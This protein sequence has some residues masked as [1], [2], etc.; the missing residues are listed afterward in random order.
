MFTLLTIRQ[1]GLYTV[2]QREAD[3]YVSGTDLCNIFGKK[4]KQFRHHQDVADCL[5]ATRADPAFRD[6]PIIEVKCDGPQQEQGVWLHPMMAYK[7]SFCLPSAE[8]QA[9]M[10]EWTINYVDFI[11]SHLDE[12]MSRRLEEEAAQFRA[13]L[14]ADYAQ[15]VS[16]VRQLADKYKTINSELSE[17]AEKYLRKIL[18]D[19][20]NH[21]DKYMC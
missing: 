12:N 3:G 4:F 11:G 5:A 6:L 20:P 14:D 2:R 1:F 16:D 8:L 13:K 19:R 7:F 10:F 15:F 21:P 17:S 18:R 9:V